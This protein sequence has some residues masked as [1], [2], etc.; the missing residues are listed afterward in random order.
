MLG[1]NKKK[2]G[3][4][5]VDP[6][7]NLKERA[8]NRNVKPYVLASLL[9]AFVVASVFI[10]DRI[11]QQ[12]LFP[13]TKVAV[14]GEL[15]QIKEIDLK[16]LVL[17]DLQQGF[18]D[19]DLNSAASDIE[20][21]NW[22]AQ[23]TLRR[24]WPNKV[25]ILLREHQAVA[26]WD[27]QTLISTNGVLFEVDSLEQFKHLAIVTGQ[28][29]NAKEL[30]LAYSELD[31]LTVDFDLQIVEL[32]RIKSGEMNVTFNTQLH[33][34]FAL[35]DKETQYKR[36]VS[37]LDSGFIK[38]KNNTNVMNEKALKSIDMRYSNGFSVV[39]H[40]PQSQLNK[41][42]AKDTNGKQHV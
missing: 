12:I 20:K 27:D 9:C 5:K 15:K 34:I 33:S 36:F 16:N 38:V 32:K 3:N 17:N 35:Q 37:L 4:R 25:E 30:L 18:F 1:L 7:R 31:Q 2:Q 19:I 24:V 13:I 29:M 6:P 21:I 23:A 26:I 22:V 40:E 11:S 41:K 8:E 28:R 10:Y 14:V 39:W 42:L